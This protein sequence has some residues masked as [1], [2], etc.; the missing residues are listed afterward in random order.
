MNLAIIGTGNVGAPV[1]RL[2]AA[3]GHK[4]VFGSR[5]P[6]K[7]AALIAAAGPNASVGSP[8]DAIEAADIVLEAVPFHAVTNLPSK[9]LAGK[10][11]LSASNYFPQRDGD[12]NLGGLSHTAWVAKQH[13][14]SRVVK[15]YSMIGGEVL[16]R[17]A[18]GDQGDGFVMFLASDD[19]EAMGTASVLARDTKLEPLEV[20]S[21]ADSRIFQ[22]VDGPLFDVRMTLVEAR[23]EVRRLLQL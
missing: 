15:A 3:A 13:P 21:L 22:P 18:N 7:H 16:E 5:S 17:Y 14:E 10:I 1:G 6:E 11:L 19:S 23:D 9:K 2:W 20:G 4:V 12:I 8:E